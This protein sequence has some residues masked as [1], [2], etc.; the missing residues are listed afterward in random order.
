MKLEC[1][2]CQ[3][4]YTLSDEK[5]RGKVVKI[6]CRRCK[7]IVVASGTPPEPDRDPGGVPRTGERNE[8][9]VLFSLSALQQARDPAPVPGSA[10]E[11]SGLID[12]RVLAQAMAR[13]EVRPDSASAIAHLGSGIFVP[14]VAGEPVPTSVAVEPRARAP[15]G[16]RLL[17]VATGAL[18]VVFVATACM[19]VLRRA[20]APPA[21]VGIASTLPAVLVSPREPEVARA[22]PTPEPAAAVTVAEVPATPRAPALPVMKSPSLP[23][24][25]TPK[26][27]D[28][29]AAAH[30]LG[31]ADLRGCA[32]AA[33]TAAG[34][35]RVTIQPSGAV[36]EV[37]V[38]T[39]ELSGTPIDWCVAAA[40][41]RVK[42]AA[43]S[44]PAVTVGK[45]FV[46]ADGA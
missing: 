26:P 13:P 9:S 38:D 29:A 46:L 30:A 24:V 15:L 16:L 22:A 2:T 42:V 21:S 7:E 17:M 27:F 37:V 8:K 36:S 28:A 1:P 31:A 18:G 20:P 11:S 40:Y 6:R 25:P 14:Q 44:G 10:L 45:R 39:P 33:P 43:F 35:A 12:L 3:A 34:H 23:S 19:L 41:R 32:K 4:R 5:V